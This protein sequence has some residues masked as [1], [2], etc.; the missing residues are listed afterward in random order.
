MKHFSGENLTALISLYDFFQDVSQCREPNSIQQ[1]Q[2]FHQCRGACCPP[3]HLRAVLPLG[4]S[5][6]GES[7]AGESLPKKIPIKVLTAFNW[8]PVLKFTPRL[9]KGLVCLHSKDS[10]L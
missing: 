10:L 3:V 7:A 5:L 8:W 2:C 6:P 1:F 9:E 4:R